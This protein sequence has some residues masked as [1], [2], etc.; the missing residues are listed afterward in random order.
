MKV[1]YNPAISGI[2]VIN[3]D[4]PTGAVYPKEVLKEIVAIAREYDLFIVC[5]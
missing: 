3:P 1:K 4:N 5:D 2:L